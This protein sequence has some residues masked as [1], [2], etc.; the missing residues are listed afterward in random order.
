MSLHKVLAVKSF[1]ITHQIHNGYAS[2][3]VMPFLSRPLRIFTR[4]HRPF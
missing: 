3:F 2:I 4:F 1:R